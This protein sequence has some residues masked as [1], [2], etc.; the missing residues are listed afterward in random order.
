MLPRWHDR[1]V[2]KVGDVVLRRYTQLRGAGTPRFNT[3]FTT[4]RQRSLSWASWIHSTPHQPVSLR[5]ILIPCSHLR[6]GLSS[7]LFP[8]GVHYQNSVHFLSS[9]VRATYPAHLTLQE[10]SNISLSLPCQRGN[11][12]VTARSRGKKSKTWDRKHMICQNFLLFTFSVFCPSTVLSHALYLCNTP[13]TE[14]YH[15]QFWIQR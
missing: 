7:G 15:I 2:F 14:L 5:S 13:C 6:L 1:C 10:A 11:I 8:S 3:A 4:A 12:A 9:P